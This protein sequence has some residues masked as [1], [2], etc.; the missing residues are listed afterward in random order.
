MGGIYAREE[1]QPEQVW[2]AIYHQYLP[3]GVEVDAPPTQAQLGDGAVAWAAVSLA[4]KLDT[5]VGLTN[6]GEKS[7]GSR[8]PYGLRRQMHGIVR[9]LMD[10]PELVGVDRELGLRT[11]VAAADTGF[12]HAAGSEAADAVVAFA[13]ERV[14]YA[15]EQRGHPGEVVRGATSATGDVVPLRVLRVAAALQRMRGAEDFQALAVLFKRVKNIARELKAHAAAR[16]WGADRAGRTG[17]PRRARCPQAPRRAGR[18]PQRTIDRRSPTWPV[19]GRWSIG[20]SRK[21]SSWQ[22]TRA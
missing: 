5:V 6:A 21:S 19:S 11:L 15:L 18:A 4:D 17:A 16:A 2:K 8:D 22:R 3:I 7:T 12:G 14:R 9:I 10:L 1:G 13:L 20:S